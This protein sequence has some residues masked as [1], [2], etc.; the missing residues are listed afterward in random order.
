MDDSSE[1]AIRSHQAAE[2]F[3]RAELEISVGFASM[4]LESKDD[5]KVERNKRHALNGDNIMLCFFA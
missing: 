1:A 2:G 5:D 4:A 3:L